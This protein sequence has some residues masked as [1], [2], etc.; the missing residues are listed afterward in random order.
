[1]KDLR[2]KLA[3]ILAA[4]GA[5][6]TALKLLQSK[7][8]RLHKKA[9]KAYNRYVK[10]T[11]KATDL[12]KEKK[13]SAAKVW[14]AR[15]VRAKA[16]SENLSGKAR[17]LV[18]PIK[19]T[20]QKAHDLDT[21]RENLKKKIGQAGGVHIDGNHATGGDGHKRLQA[22]AL[23]SAAACHSGHRRNFYSQSGSW[24]IDHCITGPSSG[25]RDDCS[26]WFTSAY[27]SAG[28]PD[29]N[30]NRYGGG[31]TGTL[32]DGGKRISSNEAMHTPGAA[33]IY[34][35]YPGHHVEFAIGDGTTHTIGHG[36]A[37]VDMGVFNLFG[38]NNF[39]CYKYPLS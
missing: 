36:S 4:I 29:P 9:A 28:L 21:A 8:A 1:M 5:T 34:G 3:R 2:A 13:F 23:A 20:V 35:S 19:A 33:I 38:D 30:S 39:T 12:R 16:H 24:D 6:G 7:H 17:K 11:D 25:H 22:V 32:M 27:K 31:Y 26:S 14:D 37:P 10:C 15:A 18:G